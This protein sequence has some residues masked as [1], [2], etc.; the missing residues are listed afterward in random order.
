MIVN[1]FFKKY[2]LFITIKYK[3]GLSMVMFCFSYVCDWEIEIPLYEGTMWR[4]FFHIKVRSYQYLALAAT[5]KTENG[6]KTY[7][8]SF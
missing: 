6:S 8:K 3:T 4:H 1:D 7:Y 2:T 5:V